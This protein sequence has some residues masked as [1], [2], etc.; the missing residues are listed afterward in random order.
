MIFTIN[1]H[2]Q[3][4]GRLVMINNTVVT[5]AQNASQDKDTLVYVEKA[6]YSR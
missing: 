1:L 5:F 2:H 6:I 4:A 3:Q